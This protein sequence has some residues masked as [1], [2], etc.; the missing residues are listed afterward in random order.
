[1]TLLEALVK[2][3]Q[4]PDHEAILAKDY[5]STLQDLKNPKS[6]YFAGIEP[7]YQW[8]DSAENEKDRI[9]KMRANKTPEFISR[10]ERLASLRPGDRLTIDFEGKNYQFKLIDSFQGYEY[11]F[12]LEGHEQSDFK[13]NLLDLAKQDPED[14]LKREMG[15]SMRR[16]S[17]NWEQILDGFPWRE[18]M[19]LSFSRKF[20]PGDLSKKVDRLPLNK[21]Q[22]KLL[23]KLNKEQLLNLKLETDRYGKIV[24]LSV[25]WQDDSSHINYTLESQ[26]GNY[27]RLMVLE[28]RGARNEYPFYDVKTE[29][30]LSKFKK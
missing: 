27:W 6:H 13:I 1:M 30:V 14:C 16:W 10:K 28:Q 21:E 24:N 23:S 7:S 17:M 12:R 9:P 26:T 5:S 25:Q 3:H 2:I 4:A 15:S 29:Q 18:R 8:D 20:G 19:P 11:R 22:A